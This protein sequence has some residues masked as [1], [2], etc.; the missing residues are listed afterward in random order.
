[1]SRVVSVHQKLP[2][3]N[4]LNTQV[5]KHYLEMLSTQAWKKV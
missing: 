1:M 4:L 3:Q 5:K 2:S